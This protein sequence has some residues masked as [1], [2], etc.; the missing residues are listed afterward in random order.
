MQY[1]NDQK[2][3]ILSDLINQE[4]NYSVR[5]KLQAWIGIKSHTH[6]NIDTSSLLTISQYG[7]MKNQ[8]EAWVTQLDIPTIFT[9]DIPAQMIE[10][11]ISEEKKEETIETTVVEPISEIEEKVQQPVS[12]DAPK[13]RTYKKKE[14]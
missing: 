7:S 13:K 4:E 1:I 6:E 12:S 8:I 11:P 14:D 5:M 2:L 9:P 3:R 10:I